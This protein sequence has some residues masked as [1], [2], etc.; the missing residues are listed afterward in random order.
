MRGSYRSWE[1][2][3]GIPAIAMTLVAC[4]AGDQ[5]RTSGGTEVVP[6]PSSVPTPRTFES[7]RHGYSVE[8]PPQWDVTEYEGT[9][10]RLGQ[11]SP[12]AEVPGEDVVA[13][14]DKASFLVANS[15]AIP[16]GMT[17]ADWLSAFDAL[18]AAGLD[19]N[20]PGTRRTR[21]I[22]GERAT[23]VEQRCQG[24]VVV[25][26]SLTHGGRGYYFTT[27]FS[28]GDSA[29]EATLDDVV[30]SIRFSDG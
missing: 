19:P 20:C 8:V 13:P 30:G 2:M 25:G 18:V 22:A 10:T 29:T 11:F 15:M 5:P 17:A 9:W 14:P 6:S 7:A 21:V 1:R 12:G 4:A 23:I 3:V 27:R 16:E 28:A 24:S 26:R